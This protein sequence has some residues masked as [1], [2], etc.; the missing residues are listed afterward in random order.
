MTPSSLPPLGVWLASDGVRLR[1]WARGH[2]HLEVVL[3]EP[4][5][6][7]LPNPIPM[8]L[9]PGEFFYARLPAVSGPLLYKLRI[10]GEGPFPDP[11]S[12]HQPEGV[13]GPSSFELT[14]FEWSDQAWR[15]VRL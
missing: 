13:H 9:E 2:R 12:R 3:Y 14:P 7:S 6:K 1:T 5:G 11:W 15:G 10:D 8:T 4:G